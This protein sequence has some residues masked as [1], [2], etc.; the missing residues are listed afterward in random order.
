MPRRGRRRG[1]KRIGYADVAAIGRSDLVPFDPHETYKDRHRRR[2]SVASKSQEDMVQ[3]CAERQIACAVKNNGHH[4]MFTGGDWVCDWWPSTAK[5]VVNKN[6]QQGV[7]VHDIIQVKGIL[8]EMVPRKP[9]AGSP[10][11]KRGKPRRV[12]KEDDDGNFPS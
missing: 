9:A 3:W 2:Q 5:F 11:K 12:K 4:W 6:F 10:S 7:H 8:Q 1:K